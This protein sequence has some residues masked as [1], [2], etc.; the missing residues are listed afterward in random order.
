MLCLAEFLS[1]FRLNLSQQEKGALTYFKKPSYICHSPI[2]IV[3]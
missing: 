3:P 1:N 2:P